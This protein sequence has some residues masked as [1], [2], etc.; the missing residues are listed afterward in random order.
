MY[1]LSDKLNTFSIYEI[2]WDGG[3]GITVDTPLGPARIDYAIQ[4]N[5]PQAGLLQLGI[6][7]LF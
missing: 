5:E 7:S 6:Q 3:I 2:Q 4:F 1:S